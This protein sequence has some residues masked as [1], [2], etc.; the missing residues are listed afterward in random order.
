MSDIF[1]SA[2]GCVYAPNAQSSKGFYSVDGLNSGTKESPILIVGVDSKDT[3]IILPVS[4]LD[5]TKIIY[6][7]GKNFGALSILGKILLGPSGSSSS[8][9]TVMSWFEQHRISENRGSPTN[10]S[11]PGGSQKVY[12][13]GLQLSPAD[14]EFHIQPFAIVGMVATPKK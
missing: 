13:Y 12:V 4:M 3:D 8:L 7:F 10:L 5:K 1:A 9:K 6:T 11:F 2:K 14:P